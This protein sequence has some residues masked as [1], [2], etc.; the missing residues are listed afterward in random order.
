MNSLF[1]TSSGAYKYMQELWRKKQSD[2]LR[3]LQRI[4]AWEYR[5]FPRV[6][7][8][9]KVS[10]CACPLCHCCMQHSECAC[11]FFRWCAAHAP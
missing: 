1:F 5:Q 4:R 11:S 6:H 7:R 2:V 3:F 8:V 9:T 10:V